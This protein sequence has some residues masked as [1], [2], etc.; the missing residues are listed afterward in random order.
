MKHKKQTVDPTGGEEY[1]KQAT[2]IMY[3]KQTPLNVTKKQGKT[4]CYAK[5]KPK[6]KKRKGWL[7]NS[8]AQQ[9]KQVIRSVANN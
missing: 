3:K 6:R 4:S 1:G 7:H 9:D 5:V 8:N 2:A